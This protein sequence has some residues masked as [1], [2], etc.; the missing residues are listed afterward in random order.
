M[1]PGFR[2]TPPPTARRRRLRPL[3]KKSA[4]ASAGALVGAVVAGA[5]NVRG[6]PGSPGLGGVWGMGPAVP[7]SITVVCAMP[8]ASLVE[9]I[10]LTVAE[11]LVTCQVTPTPE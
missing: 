3:G 5:W 7:P 2:Q 9:L 6:H 10:G 8:V 11:P 1:Q 4:P